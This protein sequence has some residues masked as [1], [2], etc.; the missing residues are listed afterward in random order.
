MSAREQSGNDDTRRGDRSAVQPSLFD[1]GPDGRLRGHVAVMPDLTPHSGL[2]VARYWYRRYLEQSGHPQ[3]TVNSYSYDLSVFELLI[4][5]KPIGEIKRRDVALFLDDTNT[6]S[7]RKR[8]LTSV[9]GMFKYLVEKVH[10]LESDPSADFYPEHIPLKTPRPLFAAEQE[11]LLAA[12]SRDGTR[13]HTAI[14]L[15]LRLGLSRAEVLQLR[16]EH[17]DFSDP[18]R[19]VIYVYYE[20]PRHRGRE[21]RLAASPEFTRIYQTLLEEE[22]AHG[23]V[24]GILPQSMNKLVER[25]ARDAGFDR[26]VSPQTLRDTFAVDQARDGA[27][28]EELLALLGLADDARNRMS[29]RRYLKLGQPPLLATEA[30]Q[31][32]RASVNH[33]PSAV[34]QGLCCATRRPVHEETSCE[35]SLVARRSSAHEARQGHHGTAGQDRRARGRPPRGG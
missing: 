23:P 2:D 11:Q 19:P 13:A 26:S 12:A 17:L 14:W 4:G 30:E 5:P 1:L 16:H 6:K 28:E 32:R 24:I 8:R 18:A 35:G 21:R 15:M 22:E 10:V 33:D 34:C 31:S 25:V 29:V 9:S 7:T 27:T 20:N 3:N